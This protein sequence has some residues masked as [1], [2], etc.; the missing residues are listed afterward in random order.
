MG[1]FQPFHLGHLEV[2]KQILKENSELIIAIGSAN[3]NYHIKSPFTAGERMWMIHESLKEANVDLR[4]IYITSYPNIE[5]NAAWYAHIKSLLPPF[6]IAYSGNPLTQILLA[7]HKIKVKKLTMIKREIYCA[8]VIRE[9]ML[10]DE[11]WEELVPPAVAKIIKTIEG[12][13]RI[14]YLAQSESDP[15]RY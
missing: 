5:N 7:E 12:V 13:K 9:R 4:R 15:M 14:K 1:R 11:N 2:V 6:D 8:T 10:K 3:H